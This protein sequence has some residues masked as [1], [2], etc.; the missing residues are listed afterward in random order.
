MVKR[1]TFNCSHPKV[2]R[3][4][5][6]KVNA[7]AQGKCIVSYQGLWFAILFVHDKTFVLE[8]AEND[9]SQ[10]ATGRRATINRPKTL[11]HPTAQIRYNIN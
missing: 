9:G 5:T 11:L 8:D 7:I 3:T 10:S 2:D 4:T 1:Q 6:N